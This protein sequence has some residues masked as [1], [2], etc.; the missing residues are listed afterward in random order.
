MRRQLSFP[1]EGLVAGGRLASYNRWWKAAPPSIPAGSITAQTTSLAESGL[2]LDHAMACIPDR[3]SEMSQD[4]GLASLKEHIPTLTMLASLV[5]LAISAFALRTSLE[6]NRIAQQAV[7]RAAGA[8]PHLEVGCS[9]SE[10]IEMMCLSDTTTALFRVLVRNTGNI[11]LDGVVVD[12]QG[13]P[14]TWCSLSYPASCRRRAEESSRTIVDFDEQLAPGGTAVI[15]IDVLVFKYLRALCEEH[16]PETLRRVTITAGF[17]A[18][19]YGEDLPVGFSVD[20][21]TGRTDRC[22]YHIEFDPAVMTSALMAWTEDGRPVDH[23]INPPM[24]LPLRQPTPTRS[25]GPFR[26]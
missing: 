19:R 11:P 2:T 13:A 22:N 17:V 14:G 5:S 20:P 25:L 18:R 6:S 24:P 12:T 3:G 7:D 4:R 9:D 1:R 23:R 16:E 10:T 15:D 8:L 26:H 21:N